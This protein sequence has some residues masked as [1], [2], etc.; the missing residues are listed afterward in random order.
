MPNT[1][2]APEVNRETQLNE[3]REVRIQFSRRKRLEPDDQPRAERQRLVAMAEG[4]HAYPSRTR[5]LSPPAPMV[6]GPQG[7][8]RVGR[9]QAGVFYIPNGSSQGPLAQLVRAHP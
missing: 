7:P 6:L 1:C 3:I 8:G 9:C 2:E 5:P 4:N